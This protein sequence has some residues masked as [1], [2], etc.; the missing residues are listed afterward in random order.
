M[1]V[2]I[3]ASDRKLLWI[4]GTLLVLMLTASVVLA[5]PGEQFNSPIPS[6]YSAQSAGAEAAYRL[7][8]Q[9]HY[10]VR[11]WEEPP[12]EL[13]ADSGVVL[14][15]LAEPIQAPSDKERKALAHFVQDG[16]HVLFVGSNIRTYFADAVA[17]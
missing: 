15:I 1:P 12:T 11:R 7:L 16:G 3:A 6:T 8:L 13:D 5:P 4:G 9:L 2:G 17:S 10:P 14:L